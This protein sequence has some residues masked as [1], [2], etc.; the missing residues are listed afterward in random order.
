MDTNRLEETASQFDRWR[1]IQL[2][3]NEMLKRKEPLTLADQDLSRIAIDFADSRRADFKGAKGRLLTIK[4][5]NFRRSTC[6]N[7]DFA[8]PCFVNV[9]F[10]RTSFKGAKLKNGLLWRCNF[11]GCDFS[12]ADLTGCDFWKSSVKGAKFDGAI[13]EGVKGLDREN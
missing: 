7:V 13:L 10:E 8:A 6:A 12:G 11:D 5:S 2:C 3:V 1:M 9:N 4:R